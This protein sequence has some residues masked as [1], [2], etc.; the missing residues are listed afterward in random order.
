[1]SQGFHGGDL[2][3]KPKVG[4]VNSEILDV[5]FWKINEKLIL[6]FESTLALCDYLPFD[7]IDFKFDCL[8]DHFRM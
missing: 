7:S 8:F 6:V 2:I 1:V 5:R 4:V 3:K